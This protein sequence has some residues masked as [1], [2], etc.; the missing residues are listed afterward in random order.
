MVQLFV[1]RFALD[2]LCSVPLSIHISSGP[3]GVVLRQRMEALAQVPNLAELVLRRTSEVFYLFFNNH[4]L[5]EG[6]FDALLVH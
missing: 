5:G 3:V 6:F 4:C 2:A 1:S